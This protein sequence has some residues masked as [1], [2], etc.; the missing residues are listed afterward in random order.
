MVSAAVQAGLRAPSGDNCQPWRFRWDGE[1]LRILFLADRA[2]SLYDIRSV[3]SWISLWAVITNMTL[4][5][6]RLGFR[7][8]VD[9]FRVGEAAGVVARVRFDEARVEVDLLAEAIA[10]RS[11]NRRPYLRK[12]LP[13]GVREELQA[14]AA[15]SP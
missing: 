9:L 8:A 3:A 7:P 13:M 1:H 15:S 5:A 4:A 12:P 10:A 11:V 6:L 14:L 2:E